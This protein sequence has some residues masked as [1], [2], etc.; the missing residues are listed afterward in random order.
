MTISSMGTLR[1]TFPT[2]VKYAQYFPIPALRKVKQSVV[3]MNKHATASLD[4]Y[5]KLLQ[6]DSNQVQQS[7]FAKLFQAEAEETLPRRE[8]QANSQSYIIA[9]SDTV[10]N[11]LTYLVWVVS[12]QPDVRDK[13][14]KELETL[15]E[16]FEE[17]DLRHLTYLHQVIDES[18]RLYGAAQS[19]LPRSVPAGGRELAGYWIPEDTTVS[20]QAYSMHR[21]EEIFANAEQFDPSRWESPTKEMRLAMMP[22]SWG[23]RGKCIVS[24]CITHS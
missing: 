18:L 24:T 5:E 3:Q 22:F 9:G 17:A 13:L 16:D 23:A 8:I 19:G 6:T 4:R 21:D 20:V 10:S 14:V 12:G 15:P 2:L 7:L 11:S 1:S